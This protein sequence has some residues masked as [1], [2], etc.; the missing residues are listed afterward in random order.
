MI[1]NFFHRK[2][3]RVILG[4]SCQETGVPKLILVL[5]VNVIK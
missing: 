1:S 2:E 4:P 5:T 3:R